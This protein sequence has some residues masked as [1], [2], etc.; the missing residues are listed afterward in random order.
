MICDGRMVDG[1]VYNRLGMSGLPDN[2]VIK[3]G[4]VCKS[5]LST[6]D[7]LKEI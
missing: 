6:S 4:R 7:L 3:N 5:H 1:D 2:I